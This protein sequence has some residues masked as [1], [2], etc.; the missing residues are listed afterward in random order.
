MEWVTRLFMYIV[1]GAILTITY[2]TIRGGIRISK[3]R[4]IIACMDKLDDE[5]V[6]FNEIDDYIEKE[7]SEEFKMKAR[8]LKMYGCIKNNRL[9]EAGQCLNDLDFMPLIYRDKFQMKIG[10]GDNEDS[11]FYYCFLSCIHLY[12]LGQ[13]EM[14]SLLK[15]IL[16]DYKVHLQYHLFYEMFDASVDCYKQQWDHGKEVFENVYL[17][18]FKR[19]R[20][21]KQMRSLYIDLA[22]CFLAKIA[23]DEGRMDDFNEK[24]KDN[25]VK[26]YQSSM[27][28]MILNDLQIKSYLK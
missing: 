11:F 3:N 20:Y 13:I 23:I 9:D 19:K 7:R 27:G 6:F 15:S 14:I 22:E 16:D 17:G 8:I 28:E 5:T 10:I 18:K 26:F 24:Y 4:K 21:S 2:N 1:L 25:L 12:R